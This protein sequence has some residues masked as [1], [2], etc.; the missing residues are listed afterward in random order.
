MYIV[1]D[2]IKGFRGVRGSIKKEEEYNW[3]YD[4]YVDY[5]YQLYSYLV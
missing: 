1:G 2:M 3:E 4:N 5:I